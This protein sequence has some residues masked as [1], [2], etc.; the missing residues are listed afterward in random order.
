MN[1]ETSYFLF[2]VISFKKYY[3]VSLGNNFVTVL[4]RPPSCGGPGQLPSLPS[5][6]S[7]PASLEFSITKSVI[8]YNSLILSFPALKPAYLFHKSFPS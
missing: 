5:L 4:W 8:I 2:Q 6:K 7:G 1:D 3:Y